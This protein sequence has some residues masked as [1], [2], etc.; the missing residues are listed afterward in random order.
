MKML[1][2]G[3][4]GFIGK[5]FVS[6][7]QKQY[8][9]WD[10]VIL[11]AFTYAA[12]SSLLEVRKTGTAVVRGDISEVDRIFEDGA[13]FD[14]V[15]NFAAESHVDNSLRGADDFV[16]TNVLG[17]QKLVEFCLKWNIRLHQVS[18]DEVFGDAIPI[19]GGFCDESSPVEPSNPYSA[20]KAGGDLLIRA[21]IRS[22]GLN[23]TISFGSNTYGPG[24]HV[25]KLIPNCAEKVKSGLPIALYGDGQHT[26]DWI[27]VEDHC[28]GILRILERGSPGQAYC[29]PGG[30]EKSNL[31]IVS[32]VCTTLGR[33]DHPVEFVSDRPGHDL[34]YRMSGLKAKE[35]LGWEPAKKTLDLAFL[36]KLPSPGR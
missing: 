32:Y 9:G 10:I 12:D 13:G 27:H 5:H 31:E 21:A 35:E 1:V 18:T 28:A 23:A 6:S 29:L 26:R 15:V 14:L 8:P 3:G 2:C 24:Q 4:A 34:C 7:A 16:H 30:N 22:H 33:P 20:S 36:R 25:E 11:D 17:V 19:R